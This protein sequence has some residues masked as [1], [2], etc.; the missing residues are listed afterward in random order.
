MRASSAAASTG[1][2][3]AHSFVGFRVTV[4]LRRLAAACCSLALGSVPRL[5]Q[6]SG[7]TCLR[8]EM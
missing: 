8:W 3:V 6:V 4:G 2:E 5:E 1:P 7:G